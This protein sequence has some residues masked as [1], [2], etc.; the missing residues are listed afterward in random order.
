MPEDLTLSSAQIARTEALLDAWVKGKGY[1][2]PLRTLHDAAPRIGVSPVFLHR[3]FQQ[4][5]GSDFRTWRMHL[6]IEDAK[7]QLLEEPDT[8]ASTIARRV[9]IQDRSN[10]SHQFLSCTG[11]T[12]LQW[13]R[14]A[15]A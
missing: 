1:R 11:M 6:R 5:K 8:P 7:V 4:V 12:P 9:G 10:F 14:Q 3:Y 2:L 15:K 13:R